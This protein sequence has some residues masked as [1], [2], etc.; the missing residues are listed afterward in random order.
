[1][2]TDAISPE[3]ISS[4]FAALRREFTPAVLTR[5]SSLESFSGIGSFQFTLSIVPQADI[6]CLS[7]VFRELVVDV[8]DNILI[9]RLKRLEILYCIHN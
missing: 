9:D 7:E 4:I 3:I 8:G 2:V 6:M 5:V 1:M